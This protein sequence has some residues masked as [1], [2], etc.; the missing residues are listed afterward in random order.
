MQNIFD[1]QIEGSLP[2]VVR[3]TQNNGVRGYIVEDEKYA[4]GRN[5]LS[6]AQDT[7]TVFYHKQPYFTGNKVKILTPL[8]NRKSDNIM[9]FMTACFQQSLRIFTWGTGS[10]VDTI[11]ETKISL[12]T[13]DGQIDFDFMES[14]IAELEARHIAELEAYLTV[15]GLKDYEL[16]TD[17]QKA[18]EV[19]KTL[20][21]GK[22]EL[23][24]LFEK[25]D[26]KKLPYK[27]KDLSKEPTG[28]YTLPC[29]TS[30][31][32]NQ[33][34]NYFAPTI[35]A[36]ILKNVISIPSNSDVYRAY[37]QSRDFTVLSD[38][39]TIRWKDKNADIT[40]KQY[41]FMVQCINKVTDLP[42]YSYKNKLGGWNVVKNKYIML[43]EINGAIDFDFMEV[44]IS[45]IQKLVIKDVV[46]Y[47]NRKIS[48]TK[49]LVGDK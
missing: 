9:R 16:T 38:A 33:G 24:S 46:L 26:T 10:T 4:N 22:H 15:T 27:A 13:K 30:S 18:I 39:Y 44:F 23:N 14:F 43:P 11:A 40:G 29:L 3:A 17:E 12:P 21:W 49:K 35:G 34:L 31:F 2:Y 8:F 37:Y 28:E 20:V 42:I 1:T 41:L 6:F 5:T 48:E 7:F 47:A 25:I 36:T 19:F 45:A 32:N